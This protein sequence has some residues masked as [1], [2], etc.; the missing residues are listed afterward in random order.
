MICKGKG[1]TWAG[2]WAGGMEWEQLCVHNSGLIMSK[3]FGV[4]ILKA[5]ECQANEFLP[6][7]ASNRET[8]KTIHEWNDM[9]KAI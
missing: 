1:M 5:F 9:I 3:M 7:P 8:S 6:Y 2:P 4:Q